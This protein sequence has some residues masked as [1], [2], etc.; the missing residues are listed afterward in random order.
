[1]RCRQAR[2]FVLEDGGRSARLEEHLSACPA[3]A[4][5]AREWTRLRS[6]MRGLA[7]QAIPEPSLGFA[8]RVVRSLQ[9]ASGAERAGEFFL[10]RV[11]R[12]FVYA[13]LLAT[14]LLF[15]VLVVPRS[16]P[17]RSAPVA[18]ANAVQPETIAAQ[19]YPIYSGQLMDT[20]FEFA[21]Q[22]G[23]R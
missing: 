2:Q 11:G 16:S 4:I 5:Y 10:E 15:G 6:G 17:V 19:N 7:L 23:S 1:M 14:L 22:S 21:P 13:A 18:V 3:C 8:S 20:D 9:E 12:R